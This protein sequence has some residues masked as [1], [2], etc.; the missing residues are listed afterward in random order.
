MTIQRPPLVAI[1]GWLA[2]AGLSVA[3]HAGF[4]ALLPAAGS[5]G[6]VVPSE[7]TVPMRVRV[8]PAGTPV[9]REDA[10]TATRPAPQADL[11]S[12]AIDR[13]ASSRPRS[14]GERSEGFLPPFAHARCFTPAAFITRPECP[15]R[16][17]VIGSAIAAALVR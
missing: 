15:D 11:K 14:C 4:L 5:V 1:P 17:A 12:A 9:S 2:A 7:V 16:R 6:Q 13:A 10:A 3:A 8:V